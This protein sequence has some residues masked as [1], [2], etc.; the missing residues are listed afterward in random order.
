MSIVA[1]RILND[2]FE[3]SADSQVTWGDTQFGT[4]TQKWAK[5]FEVKD[6]VIGGTGTAQ[7]NALMQLFLETHGIATADERGILEFLGEF[8]DW[9][10]E[11]TDDSKINNTYLVGYKGK[12]FLIEQWL[13][14]EVKKYAA[15]GSGADY[16]RAVLYFGAPTEKAVEAAIELNVY[17]ERPIV[18]IRKNLP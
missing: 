11:K 5:M 4:N 8:V 13:I 3:M 18:T 17:C 7:D 10:K 9:K 12:V 15:I 6:I 2:G 16:A 14:S 1:C